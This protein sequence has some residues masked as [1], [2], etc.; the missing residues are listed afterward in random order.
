MIN[1][2]VFPR[3]SISYPTYLPTHSHLILLHQG[4]E[5]VREDTVQITPSLVLS[6]PSKLPLSP[7]SIHYQERERENID[8]KLSFIS[9]LSCCFIYPVFLNYIADGLSVRHLSIYR[10]YYL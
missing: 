7:S 10:I 8:L 6:F 9:S 5:T 1:I 3:W 4:G 2:I